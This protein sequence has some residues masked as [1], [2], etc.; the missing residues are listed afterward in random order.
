MDIL[1]KGRYPPAVQ[2]HFSKFTDC[3]GAID[4]APDENGKL[5]GLARGCVANDGE[6]FNYAEHLNCE[7]AVEDWLNELMDHQV[8]MFRNRT[9]EAIDGFA[10]MPRETWLQTFTSQHCLTG[11][12]V[13]WTSE[14]FTAFDR[15][16][17]GAFYFWIIA[18]KF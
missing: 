9:K 18:R 7:G 4:W 12:Q 6:K 10:E 8:V 15:L 5:T 11:N 17:Q 1:S 16:E 14:V 2:E 13:W 3:T